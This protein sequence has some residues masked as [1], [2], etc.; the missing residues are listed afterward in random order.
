LFYDADE[1]FTGTLWDYG[2]PG[3]LEGAGERSS[4]V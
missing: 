2:S 4:R 1:G 3:K